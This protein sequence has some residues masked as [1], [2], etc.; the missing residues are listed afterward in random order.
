[1]RRRFF[2]T[3]ALLLGSAAAPAQ[4]FAPPE[5]IKPSDEQLKTIRTRFTKLAEAAGALRRGGAIRDPQMADVEVYGKAAQWIMQHNEWYRKE[6]PDWTL[7]VLD[8]GL[9]RATMLSRGEDRWLSEPSGTVARGYRSRI[10]G[11]VQP[12]AVTYPADYGQAANKRYRVDVVL[13]GRDTSLTEV[14]FL[15]R[16]NGDKPTPKDQDYI[17]IDIYG[18]GN[19][20]YRWAGES[21]VFEAIEMF[22]ATERVYGREPLVDLSRMVLRGFSMGGAGT[23]HLGLHRPDKW[24]V[25]GPGAGFTTTHGYV[26]NLPKQLPDYVE[27]C[28]RI[29]DAVDYAENV[30]SVPVVAYSGEKDDQRDA[31]RNIEDRLKGTKLSITHLIGKGLKHQ[32]PPEEQAKAEVEYARYA[33]Q[34][35]PEEIDHVRFVTCTLRYHRC[36]W[37]EILGLEKHYEKA[38][39]DAERTEAGYKVSTANIRAFHLQLP[40]KDQRERLTLDVDGQSFETLPYKTP[41]GGEHHVYLQK[42]EGKWQSVRPQKIIVDQMRRPQKAPGLQGPIDD[43]FMTGFLC[44]RGTGKP[45]N[46]AVYEH[47]EAS[48]KR[49][50]QEWDKFMRS[51]LPIK[52]DV[53]VNDEDIAGRNLILFGDPGSNR[54]IAQLLDSLPLKWTPKEVTLGPLSGDA[55]KHVPV[56]I[57]PS[58]LNVE[59]YVVLNSGHTFRAADFLGTNALLY[60]R[61]G[62]YALL[63]LADEKEPLKTEVVGAGLFDEFWHFRK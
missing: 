44:V 57:H 45:W 39:I 25:L 43:A 60:P 34:G 52:D 16:H 9:L 55:A 41:R 59:R 49:F 18:R 62:D 42:Q 2:F 5:P 17:R 19:N 1:M 58:P 10:D 13:H 28:L 22:L 51:P 31:A 37:V 32:F 48:L 38:V 6:Y 61:L 3:L 23:W 40:P 11:S 47:S 24:C 14:A 7:A 30:F 27:A 4:S 21:D 12:F 54:L 20:A 33:K 8:R 46:P 50:A 56:L 35:R 36:N 53:E 15:Y 26:P 29:Y 63:K